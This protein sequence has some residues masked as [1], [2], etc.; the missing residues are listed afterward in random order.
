MKKTILTF[1]LIAGVAQAI[2]MLISMSL[3]SPGADF[4]SGELVGY[5]TMIVSLSLI[6]FGVRSYRDKNLGGVITFGNAF[7]VGILI[8]AIAAAI[9]VIGWLIYYYGGD[10][11]ALMD[12]YFAQAVDQIRQSGESAD[13]I[14]QKVKE[15][16]KFKEIYKNPAAVVGITF[17]ENFPVGGIISLISAALLRRQPKG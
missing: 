16:E 3:L 12:A 11:K 15:M 6:F 8:A 10:G 2:L 1:G 7:K 14:D 9:Y 4:K 13:A 17:L 5:A